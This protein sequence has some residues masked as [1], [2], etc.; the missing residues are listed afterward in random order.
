MVFHKQEESFKSLQE[1]THLDADSVNKY[2]QSFYHGTSISDY[3]PNKNDFFDD[4][5][6]MCANA[7]LVLRLKD[8]SDTVISRYFH[9]NVPLERHKLFPDWKSKENY[10]LNEAAIKAWKAYKKTKKQVV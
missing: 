7:Y 8:F 4:Q 5:G 10:Y 2:R 1:K 6:Q 9:I 3:F